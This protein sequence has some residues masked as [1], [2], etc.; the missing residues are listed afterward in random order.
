MM[1][2]GSQWRTYRRLCHEVL[3]ERL[4]G[5]FDSHQR[6]YT[7]RFLARLLEEP[8]HFTQEVDLCVMSHYFHPILLLAHHL[9]PEACP[10]RSYYPQPTG[11]TPSQ[12]KIRS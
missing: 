4:T 10:E 1:P 11:S 9:T 7:Y 2:Y 5:S 12:P 8:G 3:N 6:K